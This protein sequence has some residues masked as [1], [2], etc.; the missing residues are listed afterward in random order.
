M[1]FTHRLFDEKSI[2]TNCIVQHIKKCNLLLVK[3]L[4]ENQKLVA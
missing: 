2:K 1:H 4:P 3:V